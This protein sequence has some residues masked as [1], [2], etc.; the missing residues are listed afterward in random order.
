MKE[1]KVA[2]VVIF[3][4]SCQHLLAGPQGG[5]GGGSL[6]CST[7][8][9]VET[10]GGHS[11]HQLPGFDLAVQKMEQFVPV[12][13]KEQVKK[14]SDKNIY[15]L[16][17]Q[18]KQLPSDVTD[19]YFGSSNPCYQ[20]DKEMFCDSR[21]TAS[22]DPKKWEKF[23]IHELVVAA[24]LSR[25]STIADVRA[26]N[27]V[28]IKPNVSYPDVARALGKHNLA[29]RVELFSAEYMRSIGIQST[30][31]KLPDWAKNVYSMQCSLYSDSSGGQGI[32]HSDR[33]INPYNQVVQVGD[34][35][36]IYNGYMYTARFF[37]V[38]NRDRSASGDLRSLFLNRYTQPGPFERSPVEHIVFV[39]PKRF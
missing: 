33:V 6:A 35:L 8:L 32:V 25:R 19:L 27:S 1:F 22:Q 28:L 36:A 3:L 14:I 10:F 30:S 12:W 16:P 21:V 9:L 5:S 26:A 34:D 23:F 37:V 38:F 4:F 17:C 2:I 24:A 20:T 18:I 29:S 11:P 7:N 39:C 31:I 15:F 13:A